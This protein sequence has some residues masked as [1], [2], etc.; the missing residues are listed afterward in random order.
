MFL[1][2]SANTVK[3]IVS[4]LICIFDESLITLQ[5][6]LYFCTLIL[7]P[8]FYFVTFSPSMFFPLHTY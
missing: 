4:I 5:H 7:F 1:T 3:L 2:M 6:V 8:G